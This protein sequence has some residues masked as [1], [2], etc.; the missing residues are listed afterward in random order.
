MTNELTKTKKPKIRLQITKGYQVVN[1]IVQ[2]NKLNTVCEEARCPNIYE[3]W[4]RRTATIMILG[5]ICTRSCG[6]CSVF[7]MGFEWGKVEFEVVVLDGMWFVDDD[8][9]G[10]RDWHG[11]LARFALGCKG[12]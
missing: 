1:G 9:R 3:C 5:D 2:N 12:T 4:D 10:E 8:E 11:N 7:G 6:F